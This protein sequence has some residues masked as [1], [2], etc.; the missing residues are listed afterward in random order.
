MERKTFIHNGVQLSYFDSG[1]K[2]VPLIVQHGLTGDYFQTKEIFPNIDQRCI[3]LECRGHGHS[4]I[5]PINELSITTFTSD[6]KA[7]M[8]HLDINIAYFSGI[9]MGAAIALQFA[10]R[11]PK[12]VKE[13]ILI[14]PAWELKASPINLEPFKAVA[15]FVEVYGC[16][17][18]LEHYLNSEAYQKVLLQSSDNANSLRNLFD[19]PASNLI[20]ILRKITTCEPNAT[21]SIINLNKINVTSLFTEND[22]LHPIDKAKSMSQHFERCE[23]IQ[24]CNKSKD[25]QQYINDCKRVFLNIVEK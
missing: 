14:R 7:L 3:T 24:I 5:G 12:M 4:D 21:P 19:Q 23:V 1:G 17:K 13:L 11:Y 2:G 9:S 25:K 6:L 20:S 16:Q 15:D 18:G 8:R 10:S 22:Y